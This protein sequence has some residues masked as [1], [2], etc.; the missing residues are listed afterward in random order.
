VSE[1]SPD[2][3]AS[4]LSIA[5][6]NW[7]LDAPLFARVLADLRAAIR[8]LEQYRNR[9][10]LVTIIDNDNDAA[11]IE[12]LLAV[13][14]LGA[15]AR[16]LR[17]GKNLGYGKAHNLVIAT[18]SAPYHLIMNPD[19]LVAEDGLLSAVDYLEAH[20]D[21]AALS[22]YASDGEGHP[23]YLCKRYP[24][25][26]DLMLRGFSPDGIRKRCHKRLDRYENRALVAQGDIAAVEL[27]S[28]CFMFCRSA[29]L[30]RAG[31]FNPVFFLYFE[32]FALSLELRKFGQLIYYPACRIVHY[33]GNAS[34]KG[35]GHIAYFVASMFKFYHRYGWKFF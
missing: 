14:G 10:V 31:G 6:V 28:G 26:L 18:T 4:L 15:Q 30:R 27:I 1:W 32:D 9:S 21:V 13:C 17:P 34:K 7:R 16:V 29:A 33:G 23:A 8:Y 20:P 3:E 2:H 24:A 11:A 12:E 25:L 22:P 35:L 19:V 5:I